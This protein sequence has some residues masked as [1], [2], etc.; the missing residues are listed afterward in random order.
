MKNQHL[1]VL[2][3]APLFTRTAVAQ[4]VDWAVILKIPPRT[5]I[6]VLT[7][8]K[9]TLCTLQKV[10]DEQLFCHFAPISAHQPKPPNGDLVFNRAEIRGVDTGDRLK[11]DLEDDSQGSLALLGAFEAGGG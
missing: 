5:L 4:A 8:Q 9:E 11:G 1:A 7:P 2:L 6:Y 10:T 3:L